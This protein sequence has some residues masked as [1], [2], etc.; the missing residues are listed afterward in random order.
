MPKHDVDI[1]NKKTGKH[2][3]TY[4][5]V[6]VGQNYAPTEEEFRAE[7]LKCARA[8]KLVPENEFDLLIAVV[9]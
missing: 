3:F 4:P 6:L 7:A 8:D 9:R 2:L 5:I 1:I